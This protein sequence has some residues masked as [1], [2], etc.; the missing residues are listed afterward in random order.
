MA[1]RPCPKAGCPTLI[2]TGERYCP[3]HQREA[4]RARGTTTERGYGHTHQ[5]ERARWAA[6]LTQHSIPCARCGNPI[7]RNAPF[8]LGHT[9][10]RK[11]WHGPEHPACN[12]ADGGRRSVRT[13]FERPFLREP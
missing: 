1:K 6:I 11:G 4:D 10:D 8:D 13:I 5:V 3:T 9:D 2:N 7:E 12:R